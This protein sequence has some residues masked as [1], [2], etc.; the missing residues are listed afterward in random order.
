MPYEENIKFSNCNY[1]E[2][3]EVC[4]YKEYY[5][6]IVKD[7]NDKFGGIDYVDIYVNCKYF[8][9]KSGAHYRDG[10]N[11]PFDDLPDYNYC[12]EN[13][14]KPGCPRCGSKETVFFAHW[15]VIPMAKCAKCG[16]EY[17]IPSNTYAGGITNETTCQTSPLKGE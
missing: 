8:S 11:K 17:Q 10:F 16:C 14:G 7:V 13:D 1:C 2:K 3:N 12:T 4:K 6:K 9:K 15:S 5:E